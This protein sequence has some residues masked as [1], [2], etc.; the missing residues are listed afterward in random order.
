MSI[1]MI[2]PIE[3]WFSTPVPDRK[4]I[5]TDLQR[6]SQVVKS[7]VPTTAFVRDYYVLVSPQYMR[8]EPTE[9]LSRHGIGS[10]SC[11]AL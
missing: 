10:H 2:G 8:T 3:G 7:L 6:R 1:I 9:H 5:W 4:S 11:L